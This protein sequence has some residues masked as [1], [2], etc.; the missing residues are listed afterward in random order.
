MNDN[1]THKS[2][3]AERTQAHFIDTTK[4]MIMKDGISNTSVRK[5]AEQAGYSYATIYNHFGDMEELL[6]Q[7]KISMM[8]DFLA[9]VKNKFPN[10]I[11]SIEDIKILNRLHLSYYFENPNVFQFFYQY[12][13]RPQKIDLPILSE[14]SN[15]WRE[16]FE[17]LAERQINSANKVDLIS[18]TLIYSIH[19]ILTLCFSNN[20]LSFDGLC[21]DLDNI[22]E[23]LLSTEELP[24]ADN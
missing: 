8:N 4:Q 23:M 10:G 21:L 17:R 15:T 7:T 18:K 11:S 24:N 6:L 14:F 5:V 1:N 9:L 19:G 22:T 16:I 3:K 2:T 13:I 12:Q 20:Q